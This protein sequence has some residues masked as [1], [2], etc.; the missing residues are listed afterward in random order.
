MSVS[1]SRLMADAKEFDRILELLRPVRR[2]PPG[3]GPKARKETDPAGEAG[4]D[5]AGEKSTGSPK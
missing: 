3:G 1:K 4:S 2:G 5:G